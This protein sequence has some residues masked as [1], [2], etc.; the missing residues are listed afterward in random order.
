MVSECIKI[1]RSV[2][3][4]IAADKSA[5]AACVLAAE[6]VLGSLF[7]AGSG[8]SCCSGSGSGSGNT[9]ALGAELELGIPASACIWV[10]SPPVATRKASSR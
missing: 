2:V 1:D 10:S 6:A 5:A 8:S 3:H 7:S 4:T 9:R